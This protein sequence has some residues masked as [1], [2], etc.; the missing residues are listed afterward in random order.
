MPFGAAGYGR[1]YWRQI[2]FFVLY[3]PFGIAVLHVDAYMTAALYLRSYENQFILIP[4]SVVSFCNGHGA[5]D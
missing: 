4:P 5:T 1:N 2:I 3:L